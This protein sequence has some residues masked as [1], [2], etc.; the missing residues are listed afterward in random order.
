M[1]EVER[2][3]PAYKPGLIDRAITAIAPVYGM[4]RLRARIGMQM[5]RN[6]YD[7]ASKSR[8]SLKRWN[9]FG[10]DADSD[11]LP[12]LDTL[13]ERSRDLVRN[14]PVAASAIKTKV[15]NVIGTGFVF[16]SIIDR[17]AVGLS[18]DAAESLEADIEREWRLFFDT[19]NVD[20]ARTCTGTDL[21]AMVYQQAKENGD[22]F[23]VLPRVAVRG[24]ARPP[25]G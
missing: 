10:G 11:I 5:V 19:K 7:G 1:K 18:D 25:G 8:R 15:T 13:R 12:D 17:D 21:C 23:V 22:V 4:K 24:A 2:R 6:A 3:A 14:N 16:K 9:P 20:V